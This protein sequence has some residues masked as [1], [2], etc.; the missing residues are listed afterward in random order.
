MKVI[1]LFLAITQNFLLMQ[2]I[3]KAVETGNFTKLSDVCTR[4]ISI[5][6]EKPF[7][8][9]G[10]I[11]RKSLTKYFNKKFVNY[12]VQKTEWSSLKNLVGLRKDDDTYAVQS[13]NLYLLSTES[14]EK[15]VYK[16]IFFMVREKGLKWKIYYLR[17]IRI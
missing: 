17:G 5:N 12:K 7:L 1:I 10:Y 13:L 8:K 14:G 9:S 16:F 6:F 11:K 2:P 3:Q 15:I 4:M